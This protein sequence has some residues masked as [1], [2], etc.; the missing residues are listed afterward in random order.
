MAEASMAIASKNSKIVII[1]QRHGIGTGAE[2]PL[3][4]R[5]IV[6]FYQRMMKYQCKS[7]GGN[8]AS[9]K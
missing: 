8:A 4:R 2:K 6:K 5:V 9:V 1:N 3:G 7:S